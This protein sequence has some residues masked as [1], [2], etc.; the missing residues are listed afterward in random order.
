MPIG[1]ESDN[2]SSARLYFSV[3]AVSRFL[4]S[5]LH[6]IVQTLIVM[7]RCLIHL[8]HDHRTHLLVFQL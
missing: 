8:T 6:H 2:S 4:L 3:Q 5:Y 1:S 7:D